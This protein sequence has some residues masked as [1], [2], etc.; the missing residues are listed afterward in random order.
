MTI[1]KIK[2]DKMTQYNIYNE[3]NPYKLLMDVIKQLNW[4]L[5]MV[6][7]ARW[8]TGLSATLDSTEKNKIYIQY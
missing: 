1:T 5:D 4:R 6:E 7:F 3:S 8:S 2:G